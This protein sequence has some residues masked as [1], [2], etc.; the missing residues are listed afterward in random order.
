ML[1]SKTL[2]FSKG[3]IIADSQE[4][5]SGLMV[6]TSGQVRLGMRSNLNDTTVGS[7]LI[8]LG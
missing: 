2:C 5:A 1:R 6:I 3:S 4:N 7:H 8:N